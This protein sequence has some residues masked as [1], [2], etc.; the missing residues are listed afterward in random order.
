MNNLI[1][2]MAGRSTRFNLDR[3]K[4][5]LTHPSSGTYMALASLGGIKL[6]HFDKLYFV[7]LKK[8]QDEFNFAIGFSNQLSRMGLLKKSE[9]I[10]LTKETDSPA[11]TVYE[12]VKQGNIQ[13][14]ILVKDSDSFFEID[15]HGGEN[16]VAYETLENVELIDAKSKSYL[17]INKFGI[18]NN[19]VEKKVISSKFSVGGYGFLNATQFSEFYLAMAKKNQEIYISDIIFEMILAGIKFKGIRTQKFEDW[20]TLDSWRTYCKGFKTYFV[21]IDGTL[22]ENSSLL[23]K[24][25]IGD[26][27]PIQENIDVLNSHYELGKSQIILT[28][29]RPEITRDETELEMHKLG[30]KYHQLIMGLQ[31]STRVLVNDFSTSNNYPTSISIN[32]PRNSSDLSKY[33]D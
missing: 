11:Q 12:A 30:V 27:A 23:F 1:M 8:H 7:F 16:Y 25:Y 3:P 4:W 19:I 14:S 6:D 5:M 20:G 33:L 9:L 10:F 15:T 31:H 28:T 22:V 2:P 32:I 24:P 17:Q 26:G 21:D 29:S 13:G 18:I